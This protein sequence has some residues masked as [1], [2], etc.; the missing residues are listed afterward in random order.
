MRDDGE[1][2]RPL[3][4][5]LTTRPSPAQIAPRCRR[6]SIQSMLV[7]AYH[8]L[9]FETRAAQS[10]RTRNPK[11]MGWGWL[12][13]L[14]GQGNSEGLGTGK[15]IGFGDRVFGVDSLLLVRDMSDGPWRLPTETALRRKSLVKPPS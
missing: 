6:V 4:S 12:G 11:K 1:R 5:V 14:P 2:N 3:K 15:F 9:V 13:S 8:Q 7:R 10:M